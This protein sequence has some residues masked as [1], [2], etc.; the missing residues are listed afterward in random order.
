MNELVG[1]RH[2]VNVISFSPRIYEPLES[3]EGGRDKKNHQI[4]AMG[5]HDSMVTLWKVGHSRPFAIFSDLFGKTVSD[6]CWHPNGMAMF[7]TSIDGTI[8]VMKFKEE[9]LGGK[10]LPTADLDDIKRAM[11]G[12]SR[13]I[14]VSTRED[15]HVASIKTKILILQCFRNLLAGFNFGQQVKTPTARPVETS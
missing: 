10:C 12:E 3:G 11:Y 1:H 15:L 14:Q 5:S 13:S 8:A 6:I 7:C 2:A 9:D 4:F